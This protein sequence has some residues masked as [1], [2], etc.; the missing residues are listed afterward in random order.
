VFAYIIRYAYKR[1]GQM[2]KIVGYR[3]RMRPYES[4]N[5]SQTAFENHLEA[6]HG[7]GSLGVWTEVVREFSTG[8]LGDWAASQDKPKD[9]L[10]HIAEHGEGHKRP[11]WDAEKFDRGE[12]DD[13]WYFPHHHVGDIII[14]DMEL[15]LD[16]DMIANQPPLP[17][18]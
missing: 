4:E 9:E 17:E 15:D 1:K 6:E 7:F 10:I 13:G 12:L 11:D 18:G 8:A 5:F 16:D 14:Y 2:T 3:A